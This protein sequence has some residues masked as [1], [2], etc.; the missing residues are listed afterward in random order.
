MT[1]PPA[2]AAGRPSRRAARR[3]WWILAAL[4]GCVAGVA[5]C[6]GGSALRIASQDRAA[7]VELTIVTAVFR[8]GDE[9]T[10]DFYLSD[11][12][13]EQIIERLALGP[14]GAP[15]NV[16]HVHLFLAPAAGQTPIAFTASNVSITYAVLTG[17]SMGVYGG[18]GFLL[19]S[20][21]VLDSTFSGRMQ[22]ATLRLL[23]G[24]PG[25][26]D[27]LGLSEMSGIVAAR[28]DD[29]FAEQIGARLTLLLAR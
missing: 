9:N 2:H 3:P 22:G 5:G 15:A 4:C 13:E 26:A 23:R 14:A 8:A 28:R 12:P 10:A 7:A 11:L 1:S 27:R 16:I 24:R 19:P 20:T 25:F 6:A 29:V 21:G 17:D 18:G